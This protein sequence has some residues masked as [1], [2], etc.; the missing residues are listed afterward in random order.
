MDSIQQT[1]LCPFSIIFLVEAAACSNIVCQLTS[2]PRF[3]VFWP[4]VF[5]ALQ[6]LNAQLCDR[7]KRLSN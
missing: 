4:P 3:S 1:F 5:R 2:N 6:V 7:G